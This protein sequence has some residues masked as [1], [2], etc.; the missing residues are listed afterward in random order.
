[1]RA[2][3]L[4]APALAAVVGC[5]I[6]TEALAWGEDGH[7]IVAEIAQ[8]RLDDN[9]R[10]AIANILRQASPTLAHASLASFASWADDY[11]ATHAETANW[12]FVDI[13]L[14]ANA[15]DPARDCKPDAANGDCIIA[16]LERIKS[17]VRC[18]T[19]EEQL[20]ALKFAVH[21][22]GDVQQPLHTVLE[23]QGG[24][25]IFVKIQMRGLVCT[26][27]CAPTTDFANFHAVWDVVLIQKTVFAWGSYVE[28]LENG[29]LKSPDAAGAEGGT[30]VDWAQEAHKAA[31]V[32]WAAKPANN[33]LTDIYYRA[34]L[35]VLDRQLAV[36]GLRLARFLNEAFASQTCPR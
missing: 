29:W 13:P 33:I 25:E 26:G 1:M 36:G 2:L 3:A 10:S 17:D 4:A 18:K 30:P 14:Q 35:P 31:Q 9:A 34:V 24:N 27:S 23:E 7:S 15:Y 20:N 6:A 16:E 5:A 19:G 8:R 21:F 22:V 12:H 32:V 28:R 11:R